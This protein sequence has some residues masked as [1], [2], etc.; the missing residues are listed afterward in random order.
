MIAVVDL[1]VQEECPAFE[2]EAINFDVLVKTVINTRW[3]VEHQINAFEPDRCILVA[4]NIEATRESMLRRGYRIGGT[5]DD[6]I[7]IYTRLVLHQLHWF[8]QVIVYER[9]EQPAITRPLEA[10][11]GFNRKHSQWCNQWYHKRWGFGNY[12][13]SF[14]QVMVP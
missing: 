9:F 3:S 14:K 2:M 5:V 10:I 4:R 7:T 13:S 12:N 1:Y 8:D 11:R 6:K